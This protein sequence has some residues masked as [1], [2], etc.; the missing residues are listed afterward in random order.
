MLPLNLMKW[1]KVERL[2]RMFNVFSAGAQMLF[3]RAR[4]YQASQS[5]ILVLRAENS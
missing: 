3:L 1:C 5:A 2:R 4:I